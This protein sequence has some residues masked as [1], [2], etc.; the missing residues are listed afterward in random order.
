METFTGILVILAYAAAMVFIGT[1]SEDILYHRKKK[2]REE[3]IKH[4]KESRIST[5]E[6]DRYDA[7]QEFQKRNHEFLKN[8]VYASGKQTEKG[9]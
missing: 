5:P 3:Q 9:K 8:K 6:L 1:I 7:Y 4:I 2:A